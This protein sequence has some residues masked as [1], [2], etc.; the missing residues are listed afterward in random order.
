MRD[1][2]IR[3]S[4]R[5][6]FEGRVFSVQSDR[7]CLPT[8]REVDIDIVRH[9]GS[10]VLIPMA[11]QDHVVLIEQYRYAPDRWLWE[12]PAGR[13]EKDEEAENAV[14]RECEEEIGLVPEA[15]REVGRFYPTPGYCDEVMRFYLVSGLRPPPP[16][17]AAR[18]DEDEDIRV[19]T[20]TL[21]EARAMVRDGRIIDLKTAFGLGLA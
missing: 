6:R 12:L 5:L 1:S 11:D 21:S 2:P 4:S 18:A 10:V 19:R 15:V 7:V 13:I 8:G 20:F 17:S 9:G 14:R 16:D 3:L